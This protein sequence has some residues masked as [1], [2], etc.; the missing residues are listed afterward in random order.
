M[1]DCKI[2]FITCEIVSDLNFE[3]FLYFIVATVVSFL[4]L[5]KKLPLMKNLTVIS[6]N[7]MDFH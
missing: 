6:L 7:D 2:K 4:I 5:F 3:L 1:F